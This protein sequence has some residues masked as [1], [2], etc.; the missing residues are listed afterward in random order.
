[1]VMEHTN[2]RALDPR[3]F[4]EQPT[5]AVVDVSFISLE[6][7]LPAVFGV[8]SSAARSSPS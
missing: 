2:A 8:L 7:I 3:G 1:M 6:K 5:L 4:A